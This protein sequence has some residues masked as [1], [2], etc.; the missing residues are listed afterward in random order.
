MKNEKRM[1]AGFLHASVAWNVGI[2]YNWTNLY[3]NGFAGGVVAIFLV[4]I[5]LA[6]KDR[7]KP[8][9]IYDEKAKELAI[10]DKLFEKPEKK[11]PKNIFWK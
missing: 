3:N 6:I 10:K 4:S 2:L 5:I 7:Q 1:V 9:A 8:M 11:I